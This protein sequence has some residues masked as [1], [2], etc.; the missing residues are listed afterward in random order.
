MSISFTEASNAQNM[1]CC[2]IYVIWCP[3]LFALPSRRSSLACPLI[4]TDRPIEINSFPEFSNCKG[5]SVEIGEAFIS[6]VIYNFV[7]III[8][9]GTVINKLTM[10]V[11][12]LLS[13]SAAIDEFLI[14]K[15]GFRPTLEQ[16]IISIFQ[17]NLFVRFSINNQGTRNLKHSF[18]G[19][20]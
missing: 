16:C 20:N 6:K 4:F 19:F 11:K 9:I 14:V 12:F 15:L 18:L 5:A 1:M 2:F 7:P 8:D 10:I 3:E 17:G 13:L